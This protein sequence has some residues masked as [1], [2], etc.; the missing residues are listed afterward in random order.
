MI[1]QIK[2]SSVSR[3]FVKATSEQMREFMERD[4]SGLQLCAMFIDG[5]DFKGQ[6]VVVA[7]GLD[8]EGRK[9]VLGLR[10]GATE[11]GAVCMGLLEDM[12]RRGLNVGDDCLFVLD[13]GKALR[14]A[15]ARVY[16]AEALVQ[17][18]Q[19]HKR[20]NVREHLPPEHQETA[21]ARIRAAYNMASYGDAIVALRHIDAG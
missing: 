3:H 4:L 10:E 17:R 21:D 12:A 11:N 6:M 1:V 2:K 19:A 14:S 5:I 18:C 7:L 16:G 9:H 15:V 13:G 8:T 20:R